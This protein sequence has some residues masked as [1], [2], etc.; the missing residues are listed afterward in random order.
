MKWRKRDLWQALHF[1][2]DFILLKTCSATASIQKYN[3]TTW[4]EAV[5]LKK[6][7]FCRAQLLAARQNLGFLDIKYKLCVSSFFSWPKQGFL[8]GIVLKEKHI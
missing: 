8:R 3:N 2:A 6:S 7:S 1:G 4:K 5:K